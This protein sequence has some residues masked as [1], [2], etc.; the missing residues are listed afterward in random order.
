EAETRRVPASD[1]GREPEAFE[2]VAERIPDVLAQIRVIADHS[3]SEERLDYRTGE[4]NA[5]IAIGGNT[6]SRGLTLEGLVSSLFIRPTNTY[7]SLLQMGRWF[8]FRTGYEDLPRLW[9]TRV[10]HEAFRHLSLD[11]HEMRQ[12]MEVYQLRGETPTDVAVKIRAHPSLRVTAKMGAAQPAVISFAG[13]RLQTRFF[14]RYDREWLEAN[15]AA[16]EHLL[17]RAQTRTTPV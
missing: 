13:S 4:S 8:G 9:T 11:E 17:A 12:D 6:L 16:A 2:Q 7:D 15:H 1:W 3:Y 10:L 14:H 5:I